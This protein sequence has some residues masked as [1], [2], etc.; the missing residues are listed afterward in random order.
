[1]KTQTKAAKQASEFLAV[2]HKYGFR[3]EVLGNTLVRITRE[4][5]PGSLEEFVECDMMYGEVLALAPLK[6]GSVW[7]TDG[8]SVGGQAAVRSGKFV[9]NKSGSAYRFM[10]ALIAA[11]VSK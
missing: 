9:M 3:V 6:G 10:T 2:A 5:T 4:I 11:Q 1:M 7:G 8:G